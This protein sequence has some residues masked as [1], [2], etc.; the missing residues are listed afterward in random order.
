MAA[1]SC[2]SFM[3]FSGTWLRTNRFGGTA[4]GFAGPT[5]DEVVASGCSIVRCAAESDSSGWGA[6]K[7]APRGLDEEKSRQQIRSHD[8][9]HWR[10]RAGAC[11]VRV[12]GVLV[13]RSN[14]RWR[15]P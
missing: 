6:E 4:A 7:K 10:G 3:M 2:G 8:D 11:R 15:N 9:H 12:F 1:Y 13:D 5:S 14:G